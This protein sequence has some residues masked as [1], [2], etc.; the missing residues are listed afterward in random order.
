MKKINFNC[1]IDS[2]DV[3]NNNLEFQSKNDSFLIK[4]EKQQD[5]IYKYSLGRLL[6]N[7]KVKDYDKF[8][9]QLSLVEVEK[10]MSNDELVYLYKIEKIAGIYCYRFKSIFNN[11]EM[12]FKC[13]SRDKIKNLEIDD[14]V[15]NMYF[16]KLNKAI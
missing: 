3:I 14:S 16:E 1:F 9:I 5:G 7:K 12:E 8:E 13:L 10:C 6:K 11:K 2:G 15:Y 4:F